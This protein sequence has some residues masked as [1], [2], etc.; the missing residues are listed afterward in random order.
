MTN[1]FKP[2]QKDVTRNKES[3]KAEK[4]LNVGVGHKNPITTKSPDINK[5][6]KNPKK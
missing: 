4:R 6:V 2:S 5:E 3:T 1:Q